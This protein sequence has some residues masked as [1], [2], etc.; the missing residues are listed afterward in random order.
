MLRLQGTWQN[1]FSYTPSPHEFE[2]GS[3][4]SRSFDELSNV[5]S[6]WSKRKESTELVYPERYCRPFLTRHKSPSKLT[7]SSVTA[8]VIPSRR[9]RWEYFLHSLAIG[10]NPWIRYLKLWAPTWPPF[11]GSDSLWSSHKCLGI[12]VSQTR[13][14]PSMPKAA[15]SRVSTLLGKSGIISFGVR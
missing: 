4:C 12:K 10:M 9:L 14:R 13:I 3:A 2:R 7:T 6:R 15:S 8:T 11:S 1:F 5:P